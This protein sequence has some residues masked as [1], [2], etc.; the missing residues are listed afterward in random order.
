MTTFSE[1]PAMAEDEISP[2]TNNCTKR[3]F[4][5]TAGPFVLAAFRR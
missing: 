2:V 3:A 4:S 1:A 5:I